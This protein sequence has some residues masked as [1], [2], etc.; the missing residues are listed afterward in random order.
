MAKQTAMMMQ[1]IITAVDPDGL[2]LAAAPADVLFGGFKEGRVEGRE[3]GFEDGLD[4]G[5][6]E[7]LLV[8]KKEG[9]GV[10][11]TVGF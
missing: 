11:L 7:G 10:G 9:L 4:V 1:N 2:A 5:K 3:D 6:D 8:G